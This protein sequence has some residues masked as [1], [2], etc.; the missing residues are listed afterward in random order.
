MGFLFVR[1]SFLFVSVFFFLSVFL[2][3]K[4]FF[5]VCKRF[6]FNCKCV[7]VVD[8]RTNHLQLDNTT[9]LFYIVKKG[10]T[11]NEKMTKLSQEI[12]DYLLQCQ[13][14]ITVEYLP[15]ILNVVTDKESRSLN[16][17]WKLDRHMFC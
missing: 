9:V 11:K 16:D 1:V 10:G 8:H 5:F 12:W 7:G 6:F 4:R 14:I 15:G 17:S 13:I 2:V 3:C